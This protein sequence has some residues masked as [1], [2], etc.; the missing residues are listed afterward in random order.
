MNEAEQALPIT[1]SVEIDEIVEAQNDMDEAFDERLQAREGIIN[2]LAASDGWKLL[3]EAIEERVE[4]Y[5]G[6]SYL[7]VTDLKQLNLPDIGLKYT[8]ASLVASELNRIINH[9]E[10]SQLKEDGQD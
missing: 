2:T 6:L 9:V 7:D 10:F 4:A 8:V 5:R 1:S 3:K